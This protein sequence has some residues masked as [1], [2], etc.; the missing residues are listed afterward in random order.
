MP[1][2]DY[3]CQACGHEFE[4]FQMMSAKPLRKC[5]ACGKLKLKRLI[6]AGAGVIFKGGGFYETDY[7]S[8]DYKKAEKAEKDAAKPKTDS[9][10]KSD[11][12]G[13]SGSSDKSGGDSGSKKADAKPAAKS[14]SKPASSSKKTGGQ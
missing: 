9:T 10:G 2:Y 5:P 11:S 14:E 6:G 4:Q 1:T 13:K 7:R 3:V 8:G 12:K